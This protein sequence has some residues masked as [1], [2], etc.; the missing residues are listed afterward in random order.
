MIIENG[1]KETITF[2]I[3]EK[4]TAKAVKSGTL[5]VLSTPSLCAYMEEAAVKTLQGRLMKGLTT[6]G[7]YIEINHLKPSLIGTEIQVSAKLI[8]TSGRKLT[9]EIIAKDDK[10]IIAKA[11]HLRMIVEEKEFL[12]NIK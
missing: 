2:K 12:N 5:E 11:K 9:F 1:I 4:E 3:S 10:K 7:F 8:E 6:V